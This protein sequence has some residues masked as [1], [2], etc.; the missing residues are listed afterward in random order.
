MKKEPL[1]D[2]LSITQWTKEEDDKLRENYPSTSNDELIRTFK[3]SLEAI[4]GRAHR[5]KIKRSGFL[6]QQTL[7]DKAKARWAARKSK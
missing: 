6:L 7:K 4:R 1:P 2:Q 3:R 5:L